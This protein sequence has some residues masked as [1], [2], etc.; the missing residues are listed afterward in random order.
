MDFQA[1]ATFIRDLLQIIFFL[2]AGT[3]TIL[4]YRHARKTV[5]QPIRTEVFKEQVK[6]LSDLSGLF[7]G[8]GE[9]ILREE[10]DYPRI[11][12]ANTHKLLDDFA[13][14]FHGE[15]VNREKRVYTEGDFSSAIV[16]TKSLM[17]ADDKY[18]PSIGTINSTSPNWGDYEFDELSVTAKNADMQEKFEKF[19]NHPLL[20]HEIRRPLQ[21]YID[22]S[23]KNLSIMMETLDS[24]SKELPDHYKDKDKMTKIPTSWISNK[25]NERIISLQ[26]LAA[27]IVS[28][29]RKYFDSDS[30]KKS[31]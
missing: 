13:V 5:L 25:F 3:V 10:L 16:N 18:A 6:I 28:E 30:L 7:A 2:I 15:K 8:K 17:R 29:I 24:V 1:W 21:V 4:T 26:P 12:A 11:Y 19:I 31:P 23:R 20:P 22:A 9:I 14:I 27:E